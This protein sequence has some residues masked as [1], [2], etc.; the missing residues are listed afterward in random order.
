M[1]YD[2]EKIKAQYEALSPDKQKQFAEM[3]KN[4]TSW[5]FQ[6]FMN[7]YNAEK[8]QSTNTV[9]NN[10][11]NTGST[12]SNNNVSN[13][14]YWEPTEYQW[15][16][17][18][19]KT[20]PYANQ[21]AG[22]YSYSDQTQYYEKN[23]QN[24]SASNSIRDKWDSMDYDQ[25]QEFLKNNP[26]AKSWI[27]K[28]GWTIKQSPYENQ[29]EWQYVYNPNTKYYEKVWG[30]GWNQWGNQWGWDYQDNSPERMQQMA[31]NVNDL[32]QSDPWIFNSE[33]S[34]R[35]FFIDWKGRT[36]E[37]EA[38]LMDLYK[39]MKIYNQY[40]WYTAEE[41]GN[42][43]AHGKVPESYLSYVKNSNPD[44]YAAI[45]DAKDKEQNKIK[46]KSNYDSLLEQ[47]WFKEEK[48]ED[49]NA[50]KFMKENWML[51]DENGDWTDDWLYPEPSEEERTMVNRVNEIIARRL[52]I[53]NIR[54]NLERD[55][56]KAYPWATKA[57][58]VALVNDAMSEL[59]AEDDDL[60][61]ELAQL[62]WQVNYEQSE[63]KLQADARQNTINNIAKNYWMY[64]QYTPEW[65][66][67]L[68]QAKY[69][70]TN[71]TLD[72]ADNWTDTQKQMALDSVL[73]DYFDKYGSII[74][75]SKNQVINDVMNYA[76]QNGVSLSQ[77]LEENFLKYLRQK[78]WYNALA[79]WQS[80]AKNKY[81]WSSYEWPDWKKHILRMNETTWQWEEL[82]IWDALWDMADL[83]WLQSKNRD[84][85]KQA[86]FNLAQQA[87]N[88]QVQA[89]LIAAAMEWNYAWTCWAYANDINYAITWDKNWIFGNDV[90]QKEWV[91]DNTEWG[92]I[93]A[94]DFVVF[95][96][97]QIPWVSRNVVPS[98]LWNT[99]LET[100]QDMYDHW[101]VWY[102]TWVDA[103][104]NITM[105]HTKSQ[106][107]QTSTFGKNTKL[108]QALYGSY[109]PVW[110]YDKS[111]PNSIYKA[112]WDAAE[113]W[114]IDK[115][116]SLAKQYWYSD[117]NTLIRQYERQYQD[118]ILPVAEWLLQKI[119]QLIASTQNTSKLERAATLK[120]EWSYVNS[121]AHAAYQSLLNDY[122]LDKLS[123]MT[124]KLS[125]MS[126]TDVK[127]VASATTPFM[128]EWYMYANDN[129]F[130]DLQNIRDSIIS[131]SAVLQ[132][133][134][135]D[136]NARN[137]QKQYYD[138]TTQRFTSTKPRWVLWGN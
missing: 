109:T 104:W 101:H 78:P 89:E 137:W 59:Q 83:D 74:Q 56:T 103:Q 113:K 77:A 10:T 44:R 76:K 100:W 86:L 16:W 125:P 79:T 67:E 75:R 64:Y 45:M 73:S 3:N 61:V 91:C 27:V 68:A 138:W 133:K 5:N 8:N 124:V 14:K 123:N 26:N 96:Y 88:P 4:D 99:D 34:F 134:Y 72:Q 111:I 106:I 69:A 15:T 80:T 94:W 24:S 46:D 57:T 107:A 93:K 47:A 32:A 136:T 85:R 131:R 98:W 18:S 122:A 6:K 90:K 38:F 25:Q 17:W 48:T 102:V 60:A 105:T 22:N 30:Q 11:Q 95:N 120:W 53:K 114:D 87:D 54:K 50:I 7:Q 121:E 110:W 112:V 31:R 119:D 92:N 19:N 36:P 65:M 84:T 135:W 42:M 62:Q 71:V 21:W 70:A 43:F 1:A 132:K 2:Y 116:E 55:Y 12:V 127:I 28:A 20:S 29:W 66:S 115:L 35:K 41:V 13:T 130:R 63:R 40:D 39:N 108:W 37:Q 97:Q 52:E 118:S 23:G 129:Y 33:D 58:I 126:D 81:N 49:T 82:D 128:N 117:Y 9:K 51:V